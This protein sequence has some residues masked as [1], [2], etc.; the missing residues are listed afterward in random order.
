MLKKQKTVYAFYGAVYSKTCLL[1]AVRTAVAWLL[2]GS[3]STV[4]A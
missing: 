1:D 2:H 4:D 3:G